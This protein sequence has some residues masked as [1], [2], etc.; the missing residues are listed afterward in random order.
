MASRYSSQSGCSPEMLRKYSTSG[1]TDSGE[2]MTSAVPSICTHGP[3][4]SSESTI[5]LTRSSRLALRVLARS[6]YVETTI[7]PASSTPHVSGDPWGRPSA[8]VVSRIAR[9]RGRTK[10]SNSASSTAVLLAILGA[11]RTR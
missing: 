2:S 6:G 4:H 1:S 8:R 10:S 11:I 5:T 7:R 3:F 9:C